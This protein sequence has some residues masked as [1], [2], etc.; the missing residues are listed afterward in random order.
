MAGRPSKPPEDRARQLHFSVSPE[1]KRQL[2]D[3]AKV[4][5][6][7]ESQVVRMAIARWHRVEFPKEGK[8]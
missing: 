6:V 5:G 4:F 1:H 3:L 2:K 7:S 8:L